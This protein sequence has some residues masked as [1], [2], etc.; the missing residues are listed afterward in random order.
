M[1]TP[2]ENPDKVAYFD[3]DDTLIFFDKATEIP[4]GSRTVTLSD[5]KGVLHDE[6]LVNM[7][8]LD[9]LREHARRGHT[10]VVWSAGGST[11]AEYVVDALDIG[12][13]VHYVLAKPTWIYDDCPVESLGKTRWLGDPSKILE[14]K[15]I[16]PK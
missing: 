5:P 7:D 15:F 8:M 1:K 9:L 2:K 16:H 12:H 14:K 10:I 6:Y 4:S 11:W 13:L 3:V